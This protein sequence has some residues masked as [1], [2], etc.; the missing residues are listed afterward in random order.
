MTGPKPAALAE[1]M[2]RECLSPPL[3]AR[4]IS[5]QIAPNL[6]QIAPSVLSGRRNP[7]DA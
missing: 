2:V 4:E 6:R 5:R 7:L 3:L 1:N